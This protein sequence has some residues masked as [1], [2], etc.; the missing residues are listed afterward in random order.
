FG[1]KPEIFTFPE[2]DEHQRI[3]TIF[4]LL[5]K[6]PAKYFILSTE[7]SLKKKTIFK[8]K[9]ETLNFTL[10][11]IY[12]REKIVE[13]LNRSGYTRT[14]FIDD[15]S[16]YAIR[17]EILDIWSAQS[18]NPY[19]ITFE[20]NR[21]ESI[22]E[23]DII[24][25][26]SETLKTEYTILPAKEYDTNSLLTDYIN[27]EINLLK[28]REI[29]LDDYFPNINF[30]KNIELFINE[31]K[32]LQNQKYEI[33]LFSENT[34]EQERLL[35]LL[36]ENGQQTDKF[37]FFI[38]KLHSGF[39][40]PAKK[41][42]FI[43]Y[44]EIFGRFLRRYQ[45]PKFKLG[46]PLE[47]LWEISQGDY[48]VHEKYGIGKFC[49]LKQ[50]SIGENT[51]EYIQI[52][53]KGKDKLYVPVSDFH[54]VQKYIGIEGKWPKLYSL[55][56]ALWERAKIRA[57]E[58]ASGLAKELYQLYTERKSI[59]GYSFPEDTEFEKIL[60]DS[61]IYTETPDQ[62]KAIEEVKKDMAKPYPMDRLILGDVG[63]GKT[64]VAIRAA[65][66]CA[67]VSKQTA[68]LAPTTV[69]AE[70]HYNVFL[71]RLKSF[72]VNIAMLTRFQS[73]KE[74]KRIV[75]DI[76]HGIIDIVIGTHRLLQKDIIFKNLGLLIIDEEHRFGVEQKEKIKLLKKSI[77]VLSLTATPIPRTLSMALS[78]IKDISLIESPPEG[79]LP[80]ETHI[81]Q[82]DE[83]IIKKAINYEIS[84]GGQVFYVHNYI[85]S[86][87]AKKKQLERLLPNI[88]FAFI[89]G[90]MKN[91]DIEKIML[92]FAHNKIDCLISTTIIEA[93]LDFPNVN[94]MIVEKAEEF[95]LSQL[96]QLRGR[97]GRSKTKAY[98]YL[99]FSPGEMTEN[100]KKRL[101]ALKEFTQLGSGFKLALRDMEIR[102]AGELLGKKQ[103]GFV[104]D[105]GLN[106]YCKYLSDEIYRLKGIQPIK[107]EKIP[108][109]DIN[110][111]AYIPEDYIPQEDIRIMF[112]RRFNSVET[113]KEISEIIDE[114]SDRFGKLPNPLEQLVEIVKIRS[115]AKRMNINRIK[116]S[117]QYIEIQFYTDNIPHKIIDYLLEKYFDEIEFTTYGFKI[118]KNLFTSERVD[119]LFF[120][121]NFLSD[122]IEKCFNI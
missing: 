19:R 61:F 22:K 34:G 112:Y 51:S 66:K 74:Q 65:F 63:F 72:P 122:I 104:Q 88:K 33:V 7:N 108:I 47:G 110:V 28:E 100:A 16:Q 121:K 6:K 30:Q 13:F 4:S 80:I 111:S 94:T 41:L 70:Q 38:G 21:V 73:K 95:G 43:T 90:K 67:L 12:S 118:R 55:D 31:L 8:E 106:L 64:E 5:N 10:G 49:G 115:I 68:V 58:S 105:V 85:P 14:D 102:G 86:I 36:E 37:K 29:F 60:A 116:E 26:R 59:Q 17:G 69:L 27:K 32:N 81:L 44:N 89:H 9:F 50:I 96:Y 98:C 53:Y 25:Q 40:S 109:I 76:K 119:T 54:K 82:Y 57:K 75:D 48:V 46:R 3:L 52:E 15:V 39:Y 120:L 113:E 83:E 114:L 11:K 18:E 24:T 35:D 107:E 99:F 42:C 79:R 71:E 77:D 91:N 20:E 103:H 117:Q 92:D 97:I 45:L 62:I 93:G 2:N 84:R 1:I 87:S 23:F 56:S 78:G 101:Y